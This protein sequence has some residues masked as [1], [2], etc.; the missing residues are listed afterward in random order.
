MCSTIF[1]DFTPAIAEL[2]YTL[3]ADRI[4]EAFKKRCTIWVLDEEGENLYYLDSEPQDDDSKN[5][6]VPEHYVRVRL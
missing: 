3:L 2:K 1:K 4:I 6:I 5:F